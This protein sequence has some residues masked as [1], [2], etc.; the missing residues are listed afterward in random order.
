MNDT[1]TVAAV[2]ITVRLPFRKAVSVVQSVAALVATDGG[3]VLVVKACSAPKLV[4]FLPPL[5]TA[6]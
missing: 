5:A 4:P 1:L 3:R 2:P 6:R